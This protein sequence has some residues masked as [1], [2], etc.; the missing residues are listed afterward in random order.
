MS[1]PPS[2]LAEALAPPEGSLAAEAHLGRALAYIHRVLPRLDEPGRAAEVQS[3][4]HSAIQQI[5]AARASHGRLMDSA[6]PNG[7]DGEMMAVIAAAVAVTVGRPHRVLDVQ[8]SS[9]SNAWANAWA[10][11]GRFHH[12]SS[13][14]VR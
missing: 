9:A 1:H 5:E 8:K 11:E 2:H 10:I 6:G 12:Y 14:K 7:I 4:L 13:H 3:A